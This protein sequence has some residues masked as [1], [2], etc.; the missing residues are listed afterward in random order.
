MLQLSTEETLVLLGR[1]YD[2]YQRIFEI[3][4]L[5]GLEL[6]KHLPSFSQIK[7]YSNKKNIIFSCIEEI[8]KQVK[9]QG[10]RKDADP[11]IKLFMIKLRGLVKGILKLDEENQQLFT[12]IILLLNQEKNMA[13]PE[14]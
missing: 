6:S 2:F 10:N 5:E 4:K 9:E 7:Q 14:N 1:E 8:E 11:K 12:Q 13:S 3:T